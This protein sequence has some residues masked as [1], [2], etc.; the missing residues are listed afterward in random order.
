MQ[1]AE[2]QETA[3]K[4]NEESSAGAEAVRRRR[5]T[6]S[7][8]SNAQVRVE[9]TDEVIRSLGGAVEVLQSR[10]VEKSTADFVEYFL[11]SVTDESIQKW[12]EKETPMEWR[13]KSALADP[14]KE[15]LIRHIF[16]LQSEMDSRSL[17]RIERA[18]L[19]D[20]NPRVRRRRL[21]SNGEGIVEKNAESIG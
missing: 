20:D 3:V 13:L 11:T 12:I 10:G 15:K 18:L 9:L 8:D 17:A 21:K 2:M 5:R 19:G 1:S 16:A 6:S 14:I 4:E 7:A